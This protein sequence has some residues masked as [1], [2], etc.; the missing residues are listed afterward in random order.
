MNVFIIL[1]IL[2]IAIGAILLL[3][4]PSVLFRFN[5]NEKSAKEKVMMLIFYGIL[6]YILNIIIWIIK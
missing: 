5:W 2:V 1:S 4:T 6:I 3:A